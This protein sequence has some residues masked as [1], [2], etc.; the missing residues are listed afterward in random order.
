MRIKAEWAI[1]SGVEEQKLQ[2]ENLIHNNADSIEHMLL[3]PREVFSLLTR[4][5]AEDRAVSS[6]SV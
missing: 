5:L 6:S 2:R 3:K 1:E 4:Q